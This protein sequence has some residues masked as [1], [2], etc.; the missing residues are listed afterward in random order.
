MEADEF[1]YRALGVPGVITPSGRGEVAAAR[2]FEAAGIG[3]EPKPWSEL[4]AE[5]RATGVAVV[6]ALVR[7][8]SK[9]AFDAVL[10]QLGGVHL[11]GI[12]LDVVEDVELPPDTRRASLV[13]QGEP[14]IQAGLEKLQELC[15][16]RPELGWSQP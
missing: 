5:M 14:L 15:E 10:G 8:L 7:H 2:L 4:P 3:R 9:G 6:E 11:R 16:K 12:I 13:F 1:L